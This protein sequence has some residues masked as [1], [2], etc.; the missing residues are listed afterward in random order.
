MGVPA[1]GVQS[2]SASLEVGLIMR[3]FEHWTPRY[4]YNRLALMAFEAR[5]LDAPWLTAAAIATLQTLIK[6]TDVGFEWGAGRSTRWFARR[7]TH[8]M[9]VESNRTWFDRVSQMLS[10]ERYTNVELKWITCDEADREQVDAYVTA[11]DAF[12]GKSLDF[13][14]VDGLARD[15]C[16]LHAV[17]KV[18]SGGLLIVDN[19]NWYLPCR[20]FSPGSRMPG[21][22]P[23]SVVWKLFL[24]S[25]K[26][27]RY[28][29]TS[30]GV[31]DTG[32]WL[33]SA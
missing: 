17:D 6:P 13:V 9:S 4:I 14:L 15:A 3:S 33:K 7:V 10:A 18:K 30:N 25:V 29:W 2:A 8:L 16:A 26:D 19:C 32:I 27:W 12:D 22:G 31:T 5:H 28:I 11:I 21:D 23:A 1:S 20:S 24:E